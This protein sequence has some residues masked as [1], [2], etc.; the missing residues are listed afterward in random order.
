LQWPENLLTFN[1]LMTLTAT[2]GFRHLR[3]TWISHPGWVAV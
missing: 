1:G 3:R 2:I